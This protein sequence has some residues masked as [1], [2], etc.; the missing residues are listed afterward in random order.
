MRADLKKKLKAIPY[1]EPDEWDKEMLARANKD[2]SEPVLYTDHLK[3][4]PKKS[5]KAVV[6]KTTAKK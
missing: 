5:K 3:Y 4:K 1:K 2:K 6:K